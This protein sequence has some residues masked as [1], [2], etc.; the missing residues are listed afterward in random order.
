MLICWVQLPADHLQVG[1]VRLR[2]V[3][4]QEE[5]QGPQMETGKIWLGFFN[6]V[7]FWGFFLYIL[8]LRMIAGHLVTLAIV[9]KYFRI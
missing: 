4:S 9:C 5:G 6:T 1:K 3:Y 7:G 2:S 8:K